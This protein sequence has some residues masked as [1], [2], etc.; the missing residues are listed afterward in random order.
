MNLTQILLSTRRLDT[1]LA[2]VWF[3]RL[4]LNSFV[5]EVVVPIEAKSASQLDTNIC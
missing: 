3:R 5:Q 2:P 1:P 4:C